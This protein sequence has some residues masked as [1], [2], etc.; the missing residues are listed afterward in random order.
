MA[1]FGAGGDP[2]CNVSACGGC[3]GALAV[4]AAALPASA[5]LCVVSVLMHKV[6]S[7]LTSAAGVALGIGTMLL[8]GA[9]VAGEPL[10]EASVLGGAGAG[11]S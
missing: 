9:A 6:I 4:S 5:V 1:T 2:A 7:C 10:L 8:V 3:G 11:C